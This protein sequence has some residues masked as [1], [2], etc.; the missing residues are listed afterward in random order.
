MNARIAFSVL[1]IVAA[2]IY[3]FFYTEAGRLLLV[4]MGFVKPSL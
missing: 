3:F 4:A 1:V 2:A